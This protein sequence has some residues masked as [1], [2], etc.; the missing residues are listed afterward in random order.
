MYSL[1]VIRSINSTTRPKVATHTNREP[2]ICRSRSGLVV[3]SAT[4]R[5]TVFISFETPAKRKFAGHF[6]RSFKACKSLRA[7]NRVVDRIF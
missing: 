7:R 6:V 2:S 4:L 3:H 5:S 1:D